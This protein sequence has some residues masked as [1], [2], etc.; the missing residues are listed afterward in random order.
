MR[1]PIAIALIIASYILPVL[2]APAPLAGKSLQNGELCQ[3][4]KLDQS[5]RSVRA[6]KYGS[7][8]TRS[9][10]SAHMRNTNSRRELIDDVLA[11]Q[12]EAARQEA[13]AEDT[14]RKYLATLEKRAL[15]NQK[16]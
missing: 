6:A 1:L 8:K 15:K 7:A 3:S 5:E 13:E 16:G 14:F 4:D 9:L 11:A 2:G 10:P 12:F